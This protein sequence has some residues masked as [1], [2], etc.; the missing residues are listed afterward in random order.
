MWTGPADAAV[1][2]SLGEMDKEEAQELVD[3]FIDD[4]E[5]RTGNPPEELRVSTEILQA[6]GAAAEA[7]ELKYGS[8]WLFL[9]L[10]LDG[11]SVE[12]G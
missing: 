4:F 3:A 2:L 8:V 11:E 10:S 12:L 7:R 5:E 9:D 6:L 1:Y